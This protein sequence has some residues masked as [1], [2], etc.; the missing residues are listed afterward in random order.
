VTA[1]DHAHAEALLETFVGHALAGFV[2][3]PD[4]IH[5]DA[6]AADRHERLRGWTPTLLLH[7]RL[8]EAAAW[9]MEPVLLALGVG[10]QMPVD[11]AAKVLQETADASLDCACFPLGHEWAVRLRRADCSKATGLAR[12]AEAL[13]I[14]GANVAAVGDWLNDLEMLRWAPRSFAMPHAPDGVKSAAT[15]VLERGGV[16]EAIARWL[17]W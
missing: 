8:A 12:V 13:G 6:P 14:D 3:S 7:P 1:I 15:D 10:E 16:A 9:R 11:R 4:A 2:F 5:G 17:G